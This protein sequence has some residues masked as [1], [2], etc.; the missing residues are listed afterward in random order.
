MPTVDDL[1]GWAARLAEVLDA[2]DHDS[3]DQALDLAAEAYTGAVADKAAAIGHVL[4]AMA[5]NRDRCRAEAKRMRSCAAKWD[6]RREA[7]RGLLS[8]LLTAHEEL[9]GEAKIRTAYG[10]AS[11]STITSYDYPDSV[12][13]WPGGFVTVETVR[14]PDRDAAKAAIKAGSAPEGFGA[15]VTRRPSW[16]PLK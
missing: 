1:E 4:D 12:D 3:M 5:D 14:R 7:V 15:T 11:M 8:R 2:A 6:G 16:R 13:E 9:T 10:T